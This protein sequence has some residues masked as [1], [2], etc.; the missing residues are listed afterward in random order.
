MR[1]NGL[2]AC[3]TV[4]HVSSDELCT[5]LLPPYPFSDEAAA[6][7]Q[8]NGLGAC[9][10]VSHR[11]VEGLGFPCGGLQQEGGNDASNATKPG[12]TGDGKGEGME[13]SDK[14]NDGSREGGDDVAKPG[15]VGEGPSEG[16]PNTDKGVNGS[17]REGGQGAKEQGGGSGGQGTHDAEESV[18]GGSLNLAGCA[19]AVFLDL[20]APPKVRAMLCAATQIRSWL[21]DLCVLDI[22]LLGLP[23]PPKVQCSMREG[24]SD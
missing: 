13:Q 20:P 11:D 3:V 5:L 23:A 1:A 4:S 19:D 6:E 16:L 22:A 2:G 7:L 24:G 10:T 17:S 14:G 9:V 21:W 15:S 18:E 8:A 12:S